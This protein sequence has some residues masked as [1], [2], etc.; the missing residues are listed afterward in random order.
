M[1]E[2]DLHA[3]AV[4]VQNR[5]T[6]LMD[7]QRLYTDNDFQEAI[8]LCVL[9][10]MENTYLTMEE[11]RQVSESVLNATRKFDFL[12]PYLED[13]SVSEIMING[14]QDTFIEKNLKK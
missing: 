2:K 13:E 5:L 4:Q 14:I 10:E 3:I 11:Q 12:Q 1:R 9:K 7:S 6:H 8:E